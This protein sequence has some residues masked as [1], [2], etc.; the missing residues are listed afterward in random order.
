M[1]KASPAISQVALLVDPFFN[2]APSFDVDL[3]SFCT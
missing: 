3:D 1:A 2:L